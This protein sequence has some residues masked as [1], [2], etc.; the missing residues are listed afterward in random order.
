MILRRGDAVFK[1]DRGAAARLPRSKIPRV[2][3]TSIRLPQVTYAYYVR[4]I[5]TRVRQ[6]R[7]A[8]C[9]LVEERFRDDIAT[10]KRALRSA[11]R[12]RCVRRRLCREHQG[13]KIARY[14]PARLADP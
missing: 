5:A 14:H 3:A 7:N 12:A 10:R 8:A 6:G 4:R 11:Q 13:P 1:G 2:L 9:G